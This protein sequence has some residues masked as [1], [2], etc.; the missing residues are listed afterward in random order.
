MVTAPGQQVLEENSRWKGKGSAERFSPDCLA[1][2]IGSPESLGLSDSL[3]IIFYPASQFLPTQGYPDV[4]YFF[5]AKN[6]N[7]LQGHFSP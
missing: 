4:K 6:G 3:Y 5:T 7:L 2:R 1:L